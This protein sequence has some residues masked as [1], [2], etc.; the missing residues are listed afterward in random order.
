MPALEQAPQLTAASAAAAALELYGVKATATALPSE[1][2][3]NFKLSLPD[4]AAYVLK[5]ANLHEANPLLDAE[6]SAMQ[7]FAS[8]PDTALAAKF[9]K[10]FRT[11]SGQAIGQF[12]SNGANH[13]VRLISFLPGVPLATVKRQ[14]AELLQDLG[15]TAAALDVV[16][17]DFKPAAIQRKFVWDLAGAAGI[18]NEHA[19]LVRDT[20]LQTLVRQLHANYL[21][22]AQPLL[23]ALPQ[24][25]IHSDLNDYN[26]LAGGGADLQ[27]RNQSITG[28]VDFGDM[29]ISQRINELAVAAAYAV[30]G[31]A[32]PLAAAGH[33]VRGY[34]RINPLSESEIA[35]LFHLI[36]ARLCM[37][38]CLAAYQQRQRPEDAYLS[39]SQHAIQ[40]ALPQL[41]GIHPRFAHYMLR[42]ACG[43]EPVPHTAH[44]VQWLR[45]NQPGFASVV[46]LDLR[47]VRAAQFDLS[48]GSALLAGDERENAAGPLTER[49][50]AQLHN[51][52]ASIGINGYDEAR[53]FYTSA[54]FAG[55]T[56]LSETRTIHMAIDLTLPAGAA[57]YA[58]LAG[59]VHGFVDATDRL[60]YGPVI[61]LRHMA[62]DTPFYTLY[63]HLSRESLAGLR[64][65][66][67]VAR[68]ERIAWIGA[69]PINGDWWPHVHF[70]IITDMLDIACNFNGSAL[71]S[72][73]EVWRSISPDPNLILGIPGLPATPR[74]AAH[75]TPALLASRSRHI[76][77]NVS[78]SYRQPLQI[79][80]GWM[81]HLY[82][83]SGR[84]YLDAYNNVPHVGHC[85]PRVV[86]AMQAQ[87]AVL[88][89]NT[90]YLQ[91][92]LAEY[93]EQLTALFP[94][95]LRV[96]FLTASGSEANELAL[97]LARAHTRQQQLIVME[98]AYHGHTST[99][100][101]ISPYKHDGP[102]GSGAPAWVH[103]TLVPDVYRGRF[104]AG[105]ADAGSQ[106]AAH[107]GSIITQLQQQPHGLCGFISETCPS[108]AGQIMLPAGYLAEVYRLVRAAGGVCIADEVQTGFGRVGTHFWAFE[109]HAVVP[110]IIV[111]GK[112]M[113]NG[114]PMGAV[115][116]T[117]EIANSFAN[118]MEY[119]STFG[120]S[121]AACAA[122]LATL[123][124]TMEENLQA[125][126]LHTGTH[127][128]A[129]LRALQTRH[130]LIGDVRGSGLFVGVE[131][132][133]DR[134]TLEPASTEAAFISDRMRELGVLLGTDGPHH[135][136]LKIRPPMP[137]DTQNADAL[138]DVLERVLT[139]DFT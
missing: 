58:P 107:V 14:S 113:G 126:A 94:A 34:H 114:Y 10:L 128:L 108:V 8:C 66:A 68:G 32:D 20:A 79:V 61:V 71:A 70:Q 127:L 122:G 129:A 106:Y 139:E 69:A 91:R 104:R 51:A 96:C 42:H 95:Q 49:L 12:K 5:V 23:A 119:F 132:V 36:N 109:Q 59:V 13:S 28:I 31:K 65:G 17:A 72:Q 133:R 98:A 87:L 27:S 138:V 48:V 75:S 90:R 121:T 21:E 84:R 38:T 86:R 101:D 50:F 40:S 92:Q 78:I 3:Q 137:F 15:A 111:L 63:G 134:I 117:P 54:A 33:V 52:R 6:N 125:H 118:G 116:T 136:V 110:D 7:L 76:G 56:P 26:V 73:R 30:L 105:A 9:P 100:I 85:H 2:D 99:L 46:D 47:S 64:V 1:R 74:P 44:V 83:E 53:V 131:L 29:L 93:S 80:R 67:P 102:G 4:G 82:D 18:V 103:K 57:L 81:Q 39:I 112:P 35:V 24:Q 97:R 123:H 135:N 37:S 60:D 22:H 62:G 43:L 55:P 45:Q 77:R 41:G 115:I 130:A 124:V 89:T 25:A 19:G 120:G 16:L 11:L 88:N